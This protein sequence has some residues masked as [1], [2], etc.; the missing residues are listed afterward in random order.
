MLQT[1]KSSL[2]DQVRNKK[3][4]TG[5]FQ[6]AVVDGL[7]RRMPLMSSFRAHPCGVALL[8]SQQPEQQPGD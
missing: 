2:G 7:L 4:I 3:P 8:G 1:Q 6:Q 5:R